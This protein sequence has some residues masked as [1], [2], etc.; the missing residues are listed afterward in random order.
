MTGHWRSQR[1]QQM[2]SCACI[3]HGQTGLA[4]K[5]CPLFAACLRHGHR[6]PLY[7]MPRLGSSYSILRV[8]RASTDSDTVGAIDDGKEEPVTMS[9]PRPRVRW[10]TRA[11]ARAGLHRSSSGCANRRSCAVAPSCRSWSLIQASTRRRPVMRRSPSLAITLAGAAPAG[12]SPARASNARA[13]RRVSC[14]ASGA[15][16]RAHADATGEKAAKPSASFCSKVC[17]VTTS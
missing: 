16:A 14:S 7:R 13:P 10:S 2:R 9:N 15:G 12:T 11:C 1:S 17:P 8:V 3:A 5:I 4:A 6:Q